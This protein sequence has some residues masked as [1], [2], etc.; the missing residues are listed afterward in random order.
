VKAKEWLA[1]RGLAKLGKGRISQAGH[2]ALAKAVSEGIKFEDYPKTKIVTT[3]SVKVG[4]RVHKHKVT[5]YE[6]PATDIVEIAPYHYNY[7]THRVWEENDSG[8]RI[9]RSLKEVCSNCRVSLVQC[10]CYDLGRI[11]SI[12][13][14]DPRNGHVNV[15]IERKR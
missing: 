11:P 8:K 7:D 10:Y 9:E 15:S 1:E 2:D 6:S 5:R 14:I 13:S 4:G 3:E 12:V